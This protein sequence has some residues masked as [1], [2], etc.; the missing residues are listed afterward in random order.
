MLFLFLEPQ[1]SDDEGSRKN[2]KCTL[3]WEV[4]AHP[5]HMSLNVTFTKNYALISLL[6]KNRLFLLQMVF[7]SG[8]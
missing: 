1:D 2:N 3:V 8:L 6:S 5:F 4:N 7:H